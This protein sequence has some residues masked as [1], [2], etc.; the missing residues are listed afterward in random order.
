MQKERKVTAL[1]EAFNILIREQEFLE[2]AK[3]QQLNEKYLG[4]LIG[5][6]TEAASSGSNIDFDI[7]STEMF[8]K[9]SKQHRASITTVEM[10]TMLLYLE[11][12]RIS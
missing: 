8:K 3:S 5:S 6:I 7:Q 11:T 1:R 9:L 12:I 10:E 4:V 2:D